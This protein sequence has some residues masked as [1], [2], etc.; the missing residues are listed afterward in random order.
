MMTRNKINLSTNE[1]KENLEQE[2]D[3]IKVEQQEIKNSERHYYIYFLNKTHLFVIYIG[4]FVIKIVRITISLYGIYLVWITL[5]F[6]ASH[7]YVK[8]C[9]PASFL[10]FIV[11]PFLT[12]T[13]HCQSL[14]WIIYNG[15]NTINNMW[16][17]IGTWLSSN[18]L[19]FT[20]NMSQESV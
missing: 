14:R 19:F 17:I 2:E 12:T 9:V 5:H 10:G 4:N 18:L 7:L 15:A 13:P 16:V 6:I 3:N 8:I 11:S 1:S 20:R